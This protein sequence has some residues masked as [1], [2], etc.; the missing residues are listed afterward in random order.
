MVS[1]LHR[2]D[3]SWVQI[4]GQPLHS[5]PVRHCSTFRRRNHPM[6]ISQ[7][8]TKH[9]PHS[10][11]LNGI[12][13]EGI[14]QFKHLFLHKGSPPQRPA[15]LHVWVRVG[16]G[17]KE[18]PL[19]E[20]SPVIFIVLLTEISAQWENKPDTSRSRC[21]FCYCQGQRLDYTAPPESV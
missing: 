21:F 13:E 1:P 16:S 12:P 14:P 7:C 19:I 10:S 3:E 9:N 18:D 4:S 15:W 8:V 17:V 6:E 20:K 2:T 11:M 5:Q